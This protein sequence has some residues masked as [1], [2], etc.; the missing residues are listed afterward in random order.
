MKKDNIPKEI[1]RKYLIYIPSSE[2]LHTL[3]ECQRSEIVQTYLHSEHPLTSRRVRK[4]GLPETGYKYYYTEKTPISFGEK[5]ELEKEI[6][7]QEYIDLLKEADSACQPIVKERYCFRYENQLFELDLYNFSD[8][9]ATLEI[10]LKSIEDPV[11]L[12]DFIS[13][14]KDVTNDNRYSN[15]SLSRTHKL[16]IF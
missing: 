13:V 15:A 10:E 3:P 7:E 6:S 5:F 12:P 14:I 11:Y 4:R 2:T 8:K 9:F 1:E 16:D